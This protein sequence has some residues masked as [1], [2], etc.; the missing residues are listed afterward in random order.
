MNKKFLLIDGNF[1]CYRGFYAIRG[2]ST[3][4]GVPTNAVLGFIVTLNKLVAEHKPGYL[5][6]A[7]D[8]KG[9]TFRHKR[10]AN[11]KVQ[12]KPMPDEL[13]TQI[14]TIKK[15]LA[16]YHIPIFEKSGY[17]ADDIIATLAKRLANSKLEIL[18]VTG[19]KDILQIVNDN[20][21]VL[22]L[23]KDNLVLDRAWVKKRFSVTPEKIVEIMALAGD[24]SDNIPG[25]PGIGEATAI[26]LIKEFGTLD[27]VL[28]NRDNIANKARSEKLKIFAEQARM[29]RELVLLDS[30]VPQ[31]AQK[32]SSQ[33]LNQ[34]KVVEADKEKLFEIFKELELKSLMAKVI[35]EKKDKID[36]KIISSQQEVEELF[37]KVSAKRAVA[38]YFWASRQKPMQAE[39][40]GLAFAFEEKLSFFFA[41]KDFSLDS[42]RPIL[43]NETIEKIGH[44][45]KYLRVLLSNHGIVLRGIGCDTMI[46]SYL[47]DPAKSRYGLSDLA[48]EY[49]NCKLDDVPVVRV[50]STNKQEA[51]ICCRN[52]AAILELAGILQNQLKEKNLFDLF[53][54]IEM[55][56]I[57]VLAEM[58]IEGVALDKDFL[59]HLSREF[60]SKL[61]GLSSNI[62][63]MA[64]ADFNINSPKQLSCILF[65]R[66]KLPKIK[67][68]KTGASTDT[69]VLES[70]S[71]LHPIAPALLEFR[72]ISKLKSTYI[73]GLIKLLNSK[74]G[75]IHSSFNQTGTATGR[76]ACSRPNLQNIPIRTKLGRKI[77]RAFLAD[78]KDNLLLSAD[79]SQI[80]LRLLAHLSGDKNLVRA[81][82]E[83]LDVHAY[84]ASLIYA[85]SQKDVT[86][87]MRN[88]A[89]TVN[90]GIAY[91]MSA[92]G[93]SKDLGIKQKQAEEFIE[94]YFQ[95]YPGVKKFIAQQIATAERT[96]FVTTLL[97][98]RRYIPQIKSQNEN[99]RQF[100]RR[101]AINTPVQG[102]ASDLIKA[103]M[104]AIYRV[105]R[106]RRLSTKMLIQ[107]HDELVF[108]LPQEELEEARALIKDKME[109]VIKLRVPIKVSIKTGKNWLEMK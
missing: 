68:T 80:E 25:V 12:R 6:V 86:V 60:E 2:L 50:P 96:G 26:E 106:T 102:S 28:A 16:A 11:Y 4:G 91:G 43:E 49:L 81:F 51:E 83:D 72:E 8:L 79:Y 55:P 59:L 78:K 31:L 56:L 101:V 76:L 89:K 69:E 82:K 61:K 38:V 20:V 13:S 22:N 64:G 3:S 10:F 62:Y 53:R 85:V 58:E 5:A 34:L 39:A 45:L 7:F 94:A 84:T 108:S 57:E 70:L 98:R 32:D 71:S 36:C 93:L 100:A 52:A 47:L 41:L 95:R 109:N 97:K 19:D 42:L 66:L 35:P 74:T 104:I 44:D 30:D 88:T 14:P 54:N 29:S 18:V 65:E 73:E 33:L 21:K 63:E 99:A 67:R 15:I 27:G 37:K 105:L 92:Y 87:Q 90:F 46:A 1:F 23:Q 17:E 24:K 75:K 48:L 107:V 40:L 103:A 9:P 77:R